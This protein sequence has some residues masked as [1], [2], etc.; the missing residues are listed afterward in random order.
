MR[1]F[2]FGRGNPN[3]LSS[4]TVHAIQ[5]GPDD[6]LWIATT[7]GGLDRFDPVTETFTRY[8]FEQGNENGLSGY[9]IRANC[10]FVDRH[11]ILWIGTTDS[12]V[13]RFDPSTGRF[14]HFRHKADD[15]ETLRP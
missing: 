5:R 12:G 10:L 15:A 13:N 4:N 6:V 7:S 2:R 3:S 11:G 9:G 14:T 1:S 8:R